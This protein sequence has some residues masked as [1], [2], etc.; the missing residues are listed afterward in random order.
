M[1]T[2]AGDALAFAL[3]APIHL[4]TDFIVYGLAAVIV[5]FWRL[6]VAFA[7]GLACTLAWKPL[8]GLGSSRREWI[9]SHLAVARL[10]G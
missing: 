7:F 2:A 8:P 9:Q 6:P 10:S 3:L 4:A 5:L 1:Q